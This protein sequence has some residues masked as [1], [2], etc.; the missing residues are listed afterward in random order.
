[1]ESWLGIYPADWEYIQ[2]TYSS[3]APK[4]LGTMGYNGLSSMYIPKPVQTK[5]YATD[6]T[7]L[8]YYKDWNPQW[9]Q[10]W[11][12]FSSIDSVNTSWLAPCNRSTS[13]MSNDAM[14]RR[15]VQY[16]GDADGVVIV[17]DTWYI[18]V[19]FWYILVS[20]VSNFKLYST[21]NPGATPL[22]IFQDTYSARCDDGFFWTAPTCRNDTTKCIAYITGGQGWGTE[23]SWHCKGS[24][25]SPTV[26][27]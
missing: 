12:F 4:D 18:L 15:H 17:N 20:F 19:S 24:L 25:G 2:R 6:G 16:T 11:N 26:P 21:Q 5:G 27:A 7:A 1:M 10:P 13:V 22:R 3:M 23:E 8:Q 9:N 14:L